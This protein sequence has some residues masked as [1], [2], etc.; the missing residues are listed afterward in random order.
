MLSTP[1][2]FL[3]FNRPETT[4]R[5]F[6]RIAEAK[7]ERLLLIA[8]GPRPGHAT[9]AA[10][11]AEVRRIV[12]NIDW[13]TEVLTN[14]SDEN[15]GC[16]RRISSGLTWVFDQVEEAIVLEDDCLPTPG[17]FRFCQELLDYYREDSRI[18]I[19][20]G[21]NFVHPK[22]STPDSYY[23]SRYTHIWGWATW[24]RTWAQY[25]FEISRFAEAKRNRL[26]RKLFPHRSTATYWEGI[27]EPV[28]RGEI[29]T[30]DYQLQ[31][32]SLLGEWLNVMPARNLVSNIG[33]GPDALHPSD[34]SEPTLNLTTFEPEFPLRHPRLFVH[35]QEADS[36]TDEHVLDVRNVGQKKPLLKRLKRRLYKGPKSRAKATLALLRTRLKLLE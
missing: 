26:F 17:F 19:I 20:S 18:G 35:S 15:L 8:D 31:F 13:P 36:Y 22:L 10:R 24:R 9:D 1:V 28:A 7:P 23:F 33:F 12:Q 30:W 2:A 29:D 4:A 5:V 21:D 34:E 16:G 6:A 25:D 3:V 11:C 14:F 27:F 32:A